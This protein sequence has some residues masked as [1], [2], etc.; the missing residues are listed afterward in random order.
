MNIVRTLSVFC[1]GIGLISLASFSVLAETYSVSSP[2]KETTIQIDVNNE[3]SYSFEYNHQSIVTTSP[4]SLTIN[5]GV[6]LGHNPK[7]TNSETRVVSETITPLYGI[8]SEI[9]D[10]YSYL[11]L[12][13]VGEYSLEVRVYDDGWGYRFLTAKEGDLTILNEGI[14]INLAQNFNV[15]VTQPSGEDH[16]ISSYEEYYDPVSVSEFGSTS[17]SLLPIVIDAGKGG[18]IGFTES[19]LHDYA[20]IQ[21]TGDDTYPRRLTGIQPKYPV[22]LEPHGHRGWI[23]A[24]TSREKYIAKTQGKRSFPWRVFI[25]APNDAALL[26]S[27]LVYRFAQPQDSDIDFSWVQPGKVAWDWW[28][29]LNVTGVDFEVGFNTETFMYYINFAAAHGL[30]YINLDDSWYHD[31]DIMSLVDDIDFDKLMA[32]AKRKNVKVVLWCVGR[33]LEAKLDEALDQF[34]KWGIAGLKI[35]FFE[36]DDQECIARL[37]HLVQETA[38]RKMTVNF[39]G[40][41]KPTGLWRTYPNLLNREAVKGMEYNKFSQNGYVTPEHVVDVPFTRMLAGPMDFTPGALTNCPEASF[42]V[43]FDLPVSWGTRC[44]QLAMYVVYFGPV[45][46]LS[47]SP[48]HYWEETDIMDFLSDVPTVWDETFPLDGKIGDF[49]LVARR[50]GSTWYVG[51]LTDEN[52]RE[53]DIDFSFLGEGSYQADIYMDGA[54]AHRNG[55]DFKRT[56]MTV[57]KTSRMTFTMAPAGGLAIKIDPK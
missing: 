49:A 1:A 3:I 39:H 43:V 15:F 5:D 56:A 19:D 11:R 22:G 55:I 2:S 20:A 37:E 7:V 8:R 35:D 34:E 26:A 28:S 29:N 9:P 21:L 33:Y 27:D 18:K 30:E 31:G 41:T 50:S 48:S 42:R 14:E 44:Q 17:Y 4:I 12:D 45:Q 6:V 25:T 46:M 36:R 40:V 47:D 57:T 53:V 13:F 32:H 54:N 16:W 10:H 51:G 52:A 23:T 24:P 38:K